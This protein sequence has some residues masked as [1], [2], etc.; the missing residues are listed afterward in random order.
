MTS[1]KQKVRKCLK[2]NRPF[3]SSWA[4]HR[5]CSACNSKNQKISESTA[6]DEYGVAYHNGIQLPQRRGA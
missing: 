4:G 2:C 5:I 3:L 6:R 1:Q